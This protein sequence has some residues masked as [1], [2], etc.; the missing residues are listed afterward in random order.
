[1]QLMVAEKSRHELT[2]HT[3]DIKLGRETFRV[4]SCIILSGSVFPRVAES[5]SMGP[6]F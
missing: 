4:V 6:A 1:M 3:P 5:L 2:R